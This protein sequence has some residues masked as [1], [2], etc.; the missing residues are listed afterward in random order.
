M[1][2]VTYFRQYIT[3]A[4]K[5][6]DV[7]QTLAHICRTNAEELQ[8]MDSDSYEAMNATADSIDDAIAAWSARP[9]N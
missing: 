3:D 5:L 2:P 9:G 6:D 4:N 7:L 8:A 1:H